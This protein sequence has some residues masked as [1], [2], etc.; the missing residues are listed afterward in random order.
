MWVFFILFLIFVLGIRV[1][2]EFIIIMLIVL[3]CINIFVIF[4]VCFFVLG[5][6]INKLL[7]LILSLLV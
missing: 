4:S 3:E 7:M 2:I 1:V 5:C 6:D